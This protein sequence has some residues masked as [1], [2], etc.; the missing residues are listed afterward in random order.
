MS[1]VFRKSKKGSIYSEGKACLAW[2]QARGLQRPYQS[3]KKDL[4]QQMCYEIKTR[5]CH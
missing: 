4:K 5:T 1:I 2:S 3:T